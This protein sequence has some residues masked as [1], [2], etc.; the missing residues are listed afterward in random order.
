[1][2]KGR[3]SCFGSQFTLGIPT[4]PS[5]LLKLQKQA[6]RS[7]TFYKATQVK[8]EGQEAMHALDPTVY[9]SLQN[10]SSA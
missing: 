1:M 9:W 8:D 7:L 2:K 6:V 10:I 4:C 5:T 3:L